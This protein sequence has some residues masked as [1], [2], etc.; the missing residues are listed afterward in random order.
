MHPMAL[1]QRSHC[2]MTAAASW[3]QLQSPY[4][5]TFT[6][7]AMVRWFVFNGTFS[8]KRL[9]RDAKCAKNDF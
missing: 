9:A 6:L 2:Q 5:Q 3:L 4:Q 7:D 8:T 1:A